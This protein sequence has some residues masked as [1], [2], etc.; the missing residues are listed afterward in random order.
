M[1]NKI[2]DATKIIGWGVDADPENEP[3]YPIKKYTGDDHKRSQWTRPSLQPAKVEIL[4]STERPYLPAVFGTPYPPRALSGVFRRLAF[5][6]SESM[7]RRWLLLILADRMDV[8]EGLIS[9]VLHARFPNL[10][11]ERGL[12]VML[13]H[14]PGMFARKVAIR[15]VILGLIG[16]IVYYNKRKN[17]L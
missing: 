14:K 15:L 13:K 10:V 8:V 2:I 5:T 9:D 7:N 1:K 11:K 6:F 16:G 17:N 4:K 12:G 3:T